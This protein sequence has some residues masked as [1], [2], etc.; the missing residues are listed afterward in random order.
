MLWNWQS[1]VHS[2]CIWQL[3]PFWANSIKCFMMEIVLPESYHLLKSGFLQLFC[4]VNRNAF[5][6]KNMLLKKAYP[7]LKMCCF[8]EQRASVPA[9]K[10]WGAVWMQVVLFVQ[11][12]AGCI[13]FLLVIILHIWARVMLFCWPCIWVIYHVFIPSPWNNS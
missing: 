11:I 10:S 8:Q 1:I 3:H 5:E 6:I 2:M 13:H 7:S 9:W 12:Y 4:A